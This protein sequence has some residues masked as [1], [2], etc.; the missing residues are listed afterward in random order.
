MLSAHSQDSG[1]N[2]SEMG[3]S[4]SWCDGHGDLALQWW[5]WWQA[6]F[7]FSGH[8]LQELS[9]W[10]EAGDSHSPPQGCASTWCFICSW[11]GSHFPLRAGKRCSILLLPTT[12]SH[13]KTIIWFLS[14]QLF[15]GFSALK[16]VQLIQSGSHCY[17]P[18]ER[19]LE[20]NTSLWL[21]DV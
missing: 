12:S 13:S 4:S 6:F 10:A 11:F 19:Y 7:F 20:M 18:R 5:C 1:C 17:S 15:L 16:L 2:C 14:P 21:K 9:F 3:T 8:E